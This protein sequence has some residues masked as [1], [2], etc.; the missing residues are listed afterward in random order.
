MCQRLSKPLCHNSVHF[1]EIM[2]CAKI[3]KMAKQKYF[4]YKGCVIDKASNCELI[5]SLENNFDREKRRSIE[6]FCA[7]CSC[8]QDICKIY[9]FFANLAIFWSILCQFSDI[10]GQC[11]VNQLNFCYIQSIFSYFLVIFIYILAILAIL[12]FFFSKQ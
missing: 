5:Q 2:V 7:C 4:H 11:F 9:H 8:S 12:P 1:C 6:L 3:L 10:L